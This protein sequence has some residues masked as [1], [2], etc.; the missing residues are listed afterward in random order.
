M[1]L[2]MKYLEAVSVSVEDGRPYTYPAGELTGAFGR[3]P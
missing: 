1:E 3:E 2:M